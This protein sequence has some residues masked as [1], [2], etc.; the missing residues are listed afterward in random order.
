MWKTTSRIYWIMV[1]WKIIPFNVIAIPIPNIQKCVQ[2]NKHNTFAQ[3]DKRLFILYY[4]LMNAGPN[5][6]STKTNDHSHIN[7]LL[8]HLKRADFSFLPILAM[9]FLC[10]LFSANMKN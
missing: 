1:N 7:F 10:S 8:E 6:V 4:Y 2:C 9:H 3:T 5:S